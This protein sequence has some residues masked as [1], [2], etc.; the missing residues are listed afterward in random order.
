MNVLHTHRWADGSHGLSCTTPRMS[1]SL[2]NPD[3]KYFVWFVHCRSWRW[4]PCRWSPWL[5]CLSWQPVHR[6]S[7]LAGA[8]N[9]MCKPTLM[10][11]RWVQKVFCFFFFSSKIK[12]YVQHKMDTVLL[13][14]QRLSVWNIVLPLQYIGKWYEIQKLPTTFQK[15]ECGTATYSLKGP[16]Y[17]GVLNS[18]LL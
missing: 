16:G 2:V 1:S 17:I 18:E 6:L 4:R 9:L 14:V 8:R 5:C 11:P 13:N 7:S 3:E 15:G 10:P 12:Q